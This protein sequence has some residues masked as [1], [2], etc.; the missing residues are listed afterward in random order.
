[1][2]GK[3]S[4]VNGKFCVFAGASQTPSLTITDD[5]LLSELN[6]STNPNAGNLFNSVLNLFM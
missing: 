3:M 6:I 4:Y 2:A 5:D 1:M